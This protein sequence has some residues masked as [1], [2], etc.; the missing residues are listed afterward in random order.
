MKI[1][2]IFSL[3]TLDLY[4]LSLFEEYEFNVDTYSR[5]RSINIYLFKYTKISYKTTLHK[6]Y[7]VTI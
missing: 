1:I 3:Y 7:I 6:I 2:L 5:F 4:N